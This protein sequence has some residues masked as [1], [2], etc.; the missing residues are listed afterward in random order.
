M[1]DL[2]VPEHP[3]RFVTS[4]ALFDG[5][6][7]SINIMRRTCSRRAGGRPPRP[8]PRSQRDR[9]GRARGG[10]PGRRGQ[11]LPGRTRRVL[12]VPRRVPARRG[13]R[14]RQDLRR[15]RRGHRPRGDPPAARIRGHDLLARGRPALRARGHDQ[16]DHR[17][18]RRR[19][20]G[21]RRPTPTPCSPAT[22]CIARAITGAESG[23]LDDAL[24]S[25]IL[26]AAEAA[27]VPLLGITGTGGS[28]KSS[29]TDELVRRFRTDQQDKLR[30]AVLA[31]DP[32][33]RKG[34]GALLGDRIR[35]NALD[36]LI[37]G[38]RSSSGRWP[39]AAATSTPA[40]STT[41]SPC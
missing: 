28:G 37:S 36:S 33:R 38:D 31:I 6:D 4:S 12:R 27:N 32:T 3:V 13:R 24:R 2:H 29:L 21:R 16:P 8:Q 23:R 34:G 5:H 25:T 18:L 19:P 9:H 26:A 10:R 30:I 1:S 7:A 11:L 22:R 39:P 15:W 20:V 35:M 17:G 40:T 14:P 41:S